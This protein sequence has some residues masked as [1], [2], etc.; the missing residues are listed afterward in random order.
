VKARSLKYAGQLK[1]CED[2]L[3]RGWFMKLFF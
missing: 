2:E 3:N 1:Q